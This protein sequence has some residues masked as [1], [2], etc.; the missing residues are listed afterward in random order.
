MTC[1]S[2]LGRSSASEMVLMQ[3]SLKVVSESPKS[4]KLPTRWGEVSD[5][6]TIPWW[7]S[8]GSTPSMKRVNCC[9][10]PWVRDPT[11]DTAGH[12]TVLQNLP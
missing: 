1:I 11:I 7:G 8:S 3:W 5:P 10:R 12:K 6:C 2:V 9:R 4:W